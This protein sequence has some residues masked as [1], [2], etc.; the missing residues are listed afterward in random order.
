MAVPFYKTHFNYDLMPSSLSDAF[1]LS[2]PIRIFIAITPPRLIKSIIDCTNTYTRIT[3]KETNN[4]LDIITFYKYIQ[5]LLDAR[6]LDVSSID[7][8]YRL[9][10][11]SAIM[12]ERKFRHITS[13]MQFSNHY[14]FNKRE[15]KKV[16][17]N[18][19]TQL[20]GLLLVIHNFYTEWMKKLVTNVSGIV[21]DESRIPFDQKAPVTANRNPMSNV[22]L[23]KPDRVALQIHTIHDPI[24]NLLLSF[25]PTMKDFSIKMSQRG[26]L[27]PGSHE[28]TFVTNYLL[29]GF[30]RGTSAHR[31]IV[32]GDAWYG[33]YQNAVNVRKLGHH[34]IFRIKNKSSGL[35]TVMFDAIK[36][37][38]KEYMCMVTYDSKSVYRNPLFL[39]R[40]GFGYRNATLSSLFSDTIFGRF[41]VKRRKTGDNVVIDLLPTHSLYKQYSNAGDIANAY[42]SYL[43]IHKLYKT[44]LFKTRLLHYF[45]TLFISQT[46]LIYNHIWE[47]FKSD[48]LNHPLPQSPDEFTASLGRSLKNMIYL[49]HHHLYSIK[50]SIDIK[51]VRTQLEGGDFS[52]FTH[53]PSISSPPGDN[54][55]CYAS[56]FGRSCAPVTHI[57]LTCSVRKRGTKPLYTCDQ[58]SKEKHTT[59]TLASKY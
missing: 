13:V 30:D 16:K 35:S 34:P 25:A 57:C 19:E 46:R 40:C 2:E 20:R 58:C 44:H 21:I 7:S 11:K 49:E 29:T 51:A 18:Q 6:A 36:M 45:I 22:S 9:H 3:R 31:M 43:G 12:K 48:R 47:S 27:P 33:S 41:Y 59:H 50:Q 8:Y 5:V 55:K 38:Y 32:I 4:T 37:S 39:T 24:S 1:F 42:M 52:C 23:T 53:P 15:S 26:F 56:V 54:I 28:S 10:G 17:H 14:I